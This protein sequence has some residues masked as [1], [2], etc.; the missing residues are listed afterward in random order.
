MKM[1]FVNPP[2]PIVFTMVITPMDLQ[3]EIDEAAC[4][5][6]LRRM[7]KAGVGVYLGSGGSGEGHALEPDEMSRLY[8]IGVEECKG[9]VPVYCNPPEAR[10]AKEMI[11]KARLGVAA[12]VELIQIYQ[13]DAGHGRAPVL[14]EQERYFRDV[15]EAIDHPAALS[16][17]SASGYL[18]PV[19]L[20]AKLCNDYPHIKAVNLH[21]TTMNYFVELKD[22]IQTDIK[23]YVGTGQ[24]LGALPLGAWGC[25]AA[26]SNVAP[27]LCQSV[28]DYYLQGNLKKS[29]EAYANM[30]RLWNAMLLT[31]AV[32][33]DIP[34][35]TL[36]A[37]GLPGGPV[38]PPR[39]MA[40]KATIGK[41]R[42]RLEA[43]SLRK[44]EGL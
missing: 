43:M 30:M 42:E 15:L 28:I 18:A 37:L 20:T 14:A 7:I 2:K 8:E 35:A 26:E 6:H 24:L 12:G 41:I 27:R 33:G 34:K 4:R 17:H 31:Q 36:M 22:S 3:G 9:K 1:K 40:D 44:L 10:T 16:I 19:S 39:V 38:R 11:R 25:Q 29:A 21:G 32:S 5:L 13:L 23:L